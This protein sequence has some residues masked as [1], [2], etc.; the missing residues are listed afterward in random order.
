MKYLRKYETKD[1][2]VKDVLYNPEFP[3]PSVIY[4]KKEKNVFYITESPL[5]FFF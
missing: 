1:E 3:T 5:P 4:L 2:A